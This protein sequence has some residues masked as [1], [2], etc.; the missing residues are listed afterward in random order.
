MKKEKIPT[1][2]EFLKCFLPEE[3]QKYFQITEITKTKETISLQIEELN[4]LPEEIKLKKGEKIISKGFSNPLQLQDFPIRGRTVWL[5][6][7][8]R[9]WVIEGRK[10]I[11]KRDLDL[12]IPGM[13]TT[14]GF[15]F[16]LK[17]ADRKV[18]E[19]YRAG[20]G[21]PGVTREEAIQMVQRDFM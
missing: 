6:I 1:S 21:I 4:N 9:K 19:E 8:R 2:Y 5:N 10:G 3:I 7:Y 14:K 20:C 11:I 13:K 12:Y 17:E 18:S 15:G 16:F